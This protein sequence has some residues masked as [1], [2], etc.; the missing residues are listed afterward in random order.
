MNLVSVDQLTTLFVQVMDRNGDQVLDRDEIR[1]FSELLESALDQLPDLR[2]DLVSP[3]MTPLNIGSTD[4]IKGLVN[5]ALV[6]AAGSLGLTIT[7]VPGANY[8]AV[9]ELR[10]QVD[11]RGAPLPLTSEQAAIRK[12]LTSL[13]AETL[14]QDP[15]LPEGLQIEVENPDA[16]SGADRLAFRWDDGDPLVFDVITG[17]GILKARIAKNYLSDKLGVAVAEVHQRQLELMSA[18][19]SRLSKTLARG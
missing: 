6:K 18:M 3:A 13:V 8:P 5:D 12:E 2:G 11:A 4:D 14:N 7:S 17:K 19:A 9:A 16:G 10:P 1:Q 15:R